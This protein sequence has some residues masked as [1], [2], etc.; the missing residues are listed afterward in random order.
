MRN[1]ILKY[2]HQFLTGEAWN[3][4]WYEARDP[5]VISMMRIGV[6]A[7][8]LFALVCYTPDLIKFFGP[9]GLLPSNVVRAVMFAEEA[10]AER[11]SFLYGS[12]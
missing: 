5:R 11:S 7:I 2:C 6:G 3:R 9:S 10:T 1:A 8:A 4:F 12:S